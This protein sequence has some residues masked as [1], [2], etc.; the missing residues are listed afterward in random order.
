TDRGITIA[1]TQEI[2]GKGRMEAPNIE[3]SLF[4]RVSLEKIAKGGKTVIAPEDLIDRAK[5]KELVAAEV[6]ELRVRSVLTCQSRYGVCR[7][8]YGRNMATGALVDIGEAVGIIAAQSIGEP[9]TQLTMRT[10]HTGGIAGEDITH[11]LPRV[12]ELFEARTPKGR[13]TIAKIAGRAEIHDEEAKRIVKV[14]SDDGTVE[15]YAVS[16]RQRLQVDE[17]DLVEPGDQITEGSIDPDDILEVAGIRAVQLYLVGEVQQVYKS[18]GVPIHDKHIELIV[19]QML[20]KVSVI[21]PGDTDMLPGDLEDR[22][23]FEARNAETVAS[24]KEPATARPILMG[25]TKSSLA[26]ESWLSAASFQE[27]TRVL[28]EAAIRGRS[29]ALLG[30]KENVIIGKLIPAGTGMTRYSSVNVTP[31][32]E[33]AEQ[34]EMLR[35]QDEERRQREEAEAAER[36]RFYQTEPEEADAF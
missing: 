16:R 31:S 8:C 28:T 29:D 24:G 25:I 23:I 5:M 33:V 13:A 19:R 21:E 9:G 12:Q 2:P 17:G 26:T 1:I 15:D 27:T 20:R 7:L 18:Q 11:G 34:L 10:F 32:E 30:L 22:R 35:R 36:A 4:G 6:E 3:T 14:I